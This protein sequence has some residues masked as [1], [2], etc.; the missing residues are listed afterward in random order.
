VELSEAGGAGKKRGFLFSTPSNGLLMMMERRLFFPVV[1][2]LLL[3]PYRPIHPYFDY[4]YA[5][6]FQTIRTPLLPLDESSL[7]A[8]H[9]AVRI[10]FRWINVWS[11]QRNRFIIDGEEVQ[12]EP[13]LRFSPWNRVQMIV[14]V[15]FLSQG[16]G[17]L[18]PVIERFHKSIGQTQ[19]GR[20]HFRR[21]VFNVSYEPLGLFYP[22]YDTLL[23]SRLR[24]IDFRLYPRKSYDPPWPLRTNFITPLDP[25]P[26]RWNALLRGDLKMF[27]NP[28]PYGA[29]QTPYGSAPTEIIPVE[30]QDRMGVSDPKLS[31]QF[32]LLDHFGFLDRVVGGIR[33]KAPSHDRVFLSAPGVDLALFLSVGRDPAPHFPGFSAGVSYTRF[34]MEEFYGI[35]LPSHQYALRFC[36]EYPLKKWMFQSEYLYLTKPTLHLGSLSKPAHELSFGVNRSFQTFTVSLALIENLIN[37]GVTPDIG[38]LIGIESAF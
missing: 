14:S 17:T 1:L 3:V 36:I 27:L 13:T 18:D 28:E 21:N 5:V 35:E 29:V 11:I 10:S 16:G 30:S 32:R 34:Q 4:P 20:D 38:A 37:F 6:L 23:Q 19:G 12:M 15:P 9:G 7:E 2:F 8:G 31:L 22:L 26:V 25:G 24:G 33:I